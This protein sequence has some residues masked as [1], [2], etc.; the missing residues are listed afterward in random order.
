MFLDVEAA[1]DTV[2]CNGIRHRMHETNIPTQLARLLSS[3]LSDRS[4]QVRVGRSISTP[5]VPAAGV[6]QGGVL[7]PLL[8]ALFVSSIPKPSDARTKVS[9]YAEYSAVGTVSAN[10]ILAA[11]LTHKDLKKS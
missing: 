3:Y 10:T 5:F 8:F 9:Q 1:F 7:S 2:S 6:P 4:M 11:Q